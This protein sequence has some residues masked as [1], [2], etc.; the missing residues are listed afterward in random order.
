M[1]VSLVAF[2]LLTSS[3][4]SAQSQSVHWYFYGGDEHTSDFVDAGE[5][6]RN[7]AGH[8]EVW[9]KE[10]SVKQVQAAGDKAVK[11]KER[12]ARVEAA[13]TAFSSPI[14]RVIKDPSEDQRDEVV[15]EEEVANNSPEVQPLTQALFEIDCSGKVARLLSAITHKN[16]RT[17]VINEPS[18]WVHFPPESNGSN[19]IV[20]VCPA[21]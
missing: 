8:V 6:Q 7:A 13:S 1:R 10:L 17:Q 11:N 5:I 4:G 14:S 21:K 9:T 15:L 2:L 12:L 18:E 3:A 20:I 19:L 16:G